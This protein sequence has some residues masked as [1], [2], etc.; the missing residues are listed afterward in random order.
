MITFLSVGVTSRSS[1]AQNLA[2]NPDFESY[3]QCPTGYEIP[4]P[5]PL[6][7]YPWVA[8][9]WGTTDYLNSCSNPSDVGV[10]DNDPGWQMPVSGNGYAG[11]IAKATVG[12]DYR[13]YLQG[14]LVSP[15]IG[16]KWYYVSFYVSLANEYCGIQQI[17]AYFTHVPPTYNWAEPL[18]VT[19][20]VEAPP[21]TSMQIQL[22]GC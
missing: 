7:C 10:P 12:D 14:P 4:G 16:G 3:T 15:L 19:P 13:E 21:S 9:A 5:P 8:A 11:F 18:I 17:G 20:Q 1:F 6:L 22:T 2:P